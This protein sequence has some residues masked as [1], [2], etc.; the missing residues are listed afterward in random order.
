[1]ALID[2]RIAVRVLAAAGL[3]AAANVVADVHLPRLVSDGLVLQR[4]VAVRVWGRADD[5]ENVT[6]W[7][8]GERVATTVAREGR[9]EIE[10]PP[11]PAGGPHQLRIAGDNEVVVRDVLFGDVWIASG[12]SNMQ[13]PMER[14]KEKYPDDIAAADFPHIR[15]F[16]VPR[17][18]DFD[19]PRDDVSDGRWQA[20]TPATV[21][22]LSAVGFFFARALGHRYDVPIGIVSSN[23]GGS[24]AEGWMSEDAL[25]A[26]PHYLEVALRYRD[27]DYLQ[28]LIDSDTA[29]EAAWH[30]RLD[31]ADAGLRAATPWYAPDAD[32]ADWELRSVP[33][34]WANAKSG[35]V[36]GVAWYRR[37]FELPAGLAGAPA[38]LMLGR[39]VD[40]DTAWVNGVEVGNITYQYPP[41]RY[42][43]PAGVLRA[44]ENTIAV[45]VVNSAGYGGFV[46]DKPYW[47]EA[48]GRRIMLEG[49]WRFRMGAT[50]APLPPPRF[51]AYH[52]PLGFFN[53]ML[54]PL[55]PMT[56]RGV[57]WYQGETN[58]GRPAE[59]E[60]LFPAMIRDW[61][62]NFEQGDFP[63]LFVQLAN[64]MEPRELPA[65]SDWAAT[66]EAQ[67]KA[68]RE[69]NTAM[70]VAIDVGEW[71][72]IH[73]LDKRT[74]GE[75]LALAAR[76]VAYGE[77]DLV[78]SGPSPRSA[79]A[80]NGAVVIEF[81]NVGG[82]LVA[83][84]ERLREFALAGKDGRFVW[85]HATIDRNR[86]VVRSDAVPE[87]HTVRYA[88]AD[89]PINA[90]LYNEEGLPATPFELEVI[91]ADFTEAFANPGDGW[92][93]MTGDGD[94]RISFARMMGIGNIEV[95]ATDD[96]RNIWW[97]L[98]RHAL[99]PA[100][101][102]TQL[103]RR[104]R[105]LRV[106]AQV[107]S[108]VAPRRINLHVNHTRTTDFHSHLMEYDIPDTAN[109]HRISMTTHGFDA[110]PGDEV[111]V[112]LALMDWGRER[113][114]LDIDY[115]AVSVVD[116]ATTGPDLGEPLPY[117][118]TP[119]K[120]AAFDL[121]LQ[122]EVSGSSLLRVAG[123]TIATL[124]WDLQ[125]LQGAESAGWGMLQLT[126]DN[127]VRPDRSRDDYNIVRVVELYGD[128]IN[129]QLVVDVV[130][131][132]RRGAKTRIPISPPV[133]RRLL[134]GH[135]TGLAL[136]AQGDIQ[137]TFVAADAA[138]V[139]DRP[140][141]YLNL[142]G[143]T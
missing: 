3:L 43:V 89:N 85:A 57:I 140:T 77:D 29:R 47:I 93:T 125:A 126:T 65:E 73:P 62:R 30:D 109:W 79:V 19:G 108:S 53:A 111:F 128:E 81:D 48:G 25:H 26:Y 114:G 21:M 98:I 36:N 103:S 44:G 97:A 118:P 46:T 137:A 14:V 99:T 41:R 72:D 70:A 123:T 13:L 49:E 136:L 9:F 76:H 130:P 86:V 2:I 60:Q 95:D 35:A 143:E 66:R 113:F 104:D 100:V 11:R 39:I 91:A 101:D 16:T 105:E 139:R 102:A 64:F 75:R 134:S 31:A 24:A 120:P 45:R 87:P 112:Q 61:R 133:L 68:L 56:I 55:L 71:N 110:R 4:D 96:E 5:D 88:W 83:R 127:V 15:Y 92:S 129:P 8:D 135:T 63:F 80:G 117:R 28:G 116:P 84:G 17:E 138:D 142:E 94:A 10:L 107:R 23:F 67:R 7:L 122:A 58:A 74:V 38:K 115:V 37:T 69:P 51:Q 32:D 106:E 119:G 20:V 6:L 82:G 121:S 131:A 27:R 12:Q 22:D 18:Y 50:A 124:R 40:A 54:A 78:Y 132:P 33:G 1:M 141:L 90:N 34:F 59:Y 52:Q 42:D